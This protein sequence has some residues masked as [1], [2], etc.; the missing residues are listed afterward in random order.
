MNH[1][2]EIDALIEAKW[3]IPVEPAEVVLSQHAI[4][5]DN[6]I[7]QA[8]LPQSEAKYRYSPQETLSLNDHALIPGLVNLHT[9]AAM[10][11]MRG[12]AD[13]LPLM[14][15]LNQHIWPIEHQYV[16]AQFVLD[17]TQLACA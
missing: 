16:D 4:A 5:I 3:I 13:D 14:E 12:F 10:T 11:L 17:G 9:H 8:I 6:G 1:Q 7:I 15:W 2:I